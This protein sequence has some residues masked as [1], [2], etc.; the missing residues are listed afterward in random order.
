MEPDHP[1][2]PDRPAEPDRL[3]A[4]GGDA[5]TTGGAALPGSGGVATSRTARAR[6][7][8]GVGARADPALEQLFRELFGT[9]YGALCRS[10]G[11][12]IGPELRRHLDADDI[13]QEAFVKAL[14]L[15]GRLDGRASSSGD[16]AASDPAGRI[17][18]LRRI[19]T[20]KLQEKV[21][22]WRAHKRAGDEEL[23]A[24]HDLE[25]PSHL[26]TDGAPGPAQLAD[27]EVLGVIFG[28]VGRLQPD[29]RDAVLL[30]NFFRVPWSEVASILGRPTIG[31][32][33]Q[34]HQRARGELRRADLG[35]RRGVPRAGDREPGNGRPA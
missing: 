27:R 3:A 19:A 1:G 4:P 11:A 8:V 18:W 20:F 34:L 2:E 15:A 5:G 12:G 25:P 31:A 26:A 9:G 6:R 29:Q 16:D 23:G 14:E 32:A 24:D 21:R 13:V 22:Y 10:A 17:A 7:P 35:G 28:A 30:R 33:Q